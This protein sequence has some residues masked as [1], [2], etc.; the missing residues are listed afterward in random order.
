LGLQELLHVSAKQHV[1]VDT[2]ES[3]RINART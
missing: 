3:G 2:I 1:G